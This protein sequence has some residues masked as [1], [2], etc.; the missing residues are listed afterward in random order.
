MKKLRPQFS[1]SESRKLGGGIS[2]SFKSMGRVSRC[3]F[4][5]PIPSELDHASLSDFQMWFYNVVDINQ[6]EFIKQEYKAKVKKFL[7]FN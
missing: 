5:Y 3:F 4:K 7:K 1:I 6:I 2:C